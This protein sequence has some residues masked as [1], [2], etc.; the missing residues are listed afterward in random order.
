[1]VLSVIRRK[2]QQAFATIA[3]VVGATVIL[4]FLHT[5]Y[6]A[7]FRK[8][9]IIDEDHSRAIVFQTF[10]TINVLG[11]LIPCIALPVA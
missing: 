9:Y 3:T 4:E 11:L 2:I 5:D 10:T 1:M 7:D 8:R 6:F